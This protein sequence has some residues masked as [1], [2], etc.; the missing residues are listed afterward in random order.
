MTL[1]FFF[2]NYGFSFEFTAI[3][4]ITFGLSFMLQLVMRASGKRT[5]AL[6]IIFS[7][8]VEG[9]RLQLIV[10]SLLL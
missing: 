6:L 1:P 10:I 8:I 4:T 9:M 3:F 2:F 7:L 5:S